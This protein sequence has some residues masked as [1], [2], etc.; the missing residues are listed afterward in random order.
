MNLSGR[1]SVLDQLGNKLVDDEKF[2]SSSDGTTLIWTWDGR[3]RNGRTV[4]AGTYQAIISVANENGNSKA[5]IRKIGI[6]K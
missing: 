1:I 5:Y 6:K 4:G 2:E 3:N